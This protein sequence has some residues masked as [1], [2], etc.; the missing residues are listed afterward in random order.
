MQ[1]HHAPQTHFN[2]NS[3]AWGHQFDT[4]VPHPS[5]TPPPSTFQGYKCYIDA[6]TTPDS[7]NYSPRVVDLGIFIIN[8][9]VIPL[10]LCL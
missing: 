5:P 7:N 9:N 3:Q 4:A 1:V 6:A 8:T 10:F 2:T